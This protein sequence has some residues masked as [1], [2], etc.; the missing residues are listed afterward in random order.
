MIIE[1]T[2]EALDDLTE[3]WQYI[4][5]DSLINANR[6]MSN[7]LDYIQMLETFPWVGK[8]VIKTVKRLYRRISFRNYNIIYFVEE[9]VYIVL[10]Y[11][12]SR[13]LKNL[14][15]DFISNITKMLQKY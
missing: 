6:F 9:K 12:S 2:I 11:R 1:F 3:I 4:S 13:D 7:L 8:I 14:V 5:K 15:R 10:I